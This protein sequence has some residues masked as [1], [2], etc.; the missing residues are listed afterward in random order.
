L[1]QSALLTGLL[2]L[3]SATAPCADP[4]FHFT[5]VDDKIF[6]EANELDRKFEKQGLVDHDPTAQAYLENIGNRLIGQAP[7]LERVNFQFRIMRDPVENAFAL[8]NGSVYV[9]SGLIAGVRNEA[10]LAG[11]LSHEITHVTKRHAY[12]EFRSIRKKNVAADILA[13][14]GGAAPGIAGIVTLAASYA[15]QLL[16]VSSVYGY[17]RDLEREADSDGFS[18]LIHAGYSGNEMAEALETLDDRLEFEPVEPFW[19]THPKLQERIALAKERAKTEPTPNP[20]DTPENYY[21]EQFSSVIRFDIQLDLDSRRARTAVDRAQRLV[22]H[23][24]G[25]ATSLSL[26]ADAYRDLGAKTARPEGDELKGG[27][28]RDN[29][30][31]VLKRTAEEEQNELDASTRGQRALAENR[32]KAESL[33]RE[34]I[35]DAPQ[36]GDPHRGIGMLYEAE[37]KKTEA[38]T[39]YR[40]YLKLAVADANDRVRI[41]RR[42]EK[43]ASSP[44]SNMKQANTDKK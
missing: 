33:Y 31:R 21:F 39:E 43:L 1:S 14:A 12:L 35:K 3:S 41:D 9:N 32:S 42:L 23:S 19:K 2:L 22:A 17:S 36:L 11:V 4:T 13:L 34:A 38:E 20:R 27:G 7:A 18:L 10:Q 28:K 8:P 30:K 15:G 25:D 24:A 6:D 29:R 16:I 44:A 40:E 26:L 5:S 37:S